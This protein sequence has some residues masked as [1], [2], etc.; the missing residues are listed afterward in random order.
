MKVCIGCGEPLGTNKR[1]HAIYCTRSCKKK[2]ANKR[3]LED[4]KKNLANRLRA[5]AWREDNQDK[6]KET[7]RTWYKLNRHKSRANSLKYLSSKKCATPPW[8]TDSQREEMEQF[9][10]LAEDLFKVS[11][12][13]YHVDHI[14]PLQGK[15]VCGLHV[16]WNLSV[17][18]EDI[19]IA[20]RNHF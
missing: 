3:R 14:V 7:L 11:G 5:K 16:P 8:I 18:P 1:P 17:L 15:N 6:Y 10:W 2:Y 12:Q 20:K 4:P 19:N 13:R 9:H